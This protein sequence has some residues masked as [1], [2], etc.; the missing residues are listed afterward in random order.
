MERQP[1]NNAI[2]PTP[3]ISYTEALSE[4]RC[5]HKDDLQ[6]LGTPCLED[7]RRRHY[8]REELKTMAGI[9]ERYAE[10]VE[11]E[12]EVR[13]SEAAAAVNAKKKADQEFLESGRR[14]KRLRD[15]FKPSSDCKLPHDVWITIL[16]L[17]CDDIEFDG[18]RGLSVVAR[19]LC[20]MRSVNKELYSVSMPAFQHLNELCSSITDKFTKGSLHAYNYKLQIVLQQKER[21]ETLVSDPASLSQADLKSLCSSIYIARSGTKATLAVNIFEAISLKH[22]T[23]CPSQLVLLVLAEKSEHLEDLRRL[24]NKATA[25]QISQT[26]Q[27]VTHDMLN[28]SWRIECAFYSRLDCMK[29]GISSMKALEAAAAD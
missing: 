6:F 15:S 18:V 7:V 21:M 5:L 20:N 22:P 23:C 14:L 9:I 28:D 2:D 8:T 19:D 10:G 3:R 12:T 26:S 27:K 16:K 17:L 25:K 11:K 29:L 4:F 13:D 1:H 24:V